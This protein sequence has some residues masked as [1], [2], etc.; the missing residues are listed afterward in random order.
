MCKKLHI[1]FALKIVWNIRRK[2][3]LEYKRQKDYIVLLHKSIHIVF[4]VG[5][6]S[7]SVDMSLKRLK[8]RT[9]KWDY[10]ADLVAEMEMIAAI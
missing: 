2:K 1:F 3:P 5:D 8:R 9:I 7:K 6:E 10:L 4:C